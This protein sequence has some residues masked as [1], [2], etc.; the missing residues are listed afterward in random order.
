MSPLIGTA[1]VTGAARRVGRVIAVELA[2]RGMDV[3][4]H[5]RA[6]DSYA[7]ATA[8]AAQCRGL[9]RRAWVVAADLTDPDAVARLAELVVAGPGSLDL[10]VNSASRFERVP[11]ESLDVAA[12]RRAMAHNVEA[13]LLVIQ[14]LAPLVRDGGAIVNVGD[15]LATEPVVAYAAH[16]ASKAALHHLT[17]AMALALAPRLRVNLVVPGTVLPP[18][19]FSDA[20]LRYEERRSALGHLG[21]PEDVAEAVAYL[22]GARFVT[23]STL[24]VDGGRALS[25]PRGAQP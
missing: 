21:T 11:W 6:M 15:F 17:R 10:V 3:V 12:L 24:T 18:A 25:G 7:E 13:P 4:V 8:V 14:A 9:G 5:H 2:T 16:G 22:Y 20:G 1:F 19:D 23:G